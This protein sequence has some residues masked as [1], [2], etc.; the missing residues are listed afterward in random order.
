MLENITGIHV[1]LDHVVKPNSGALLDILGRRAMRNP[2][3]ARRGT[4]LKPVATVF[5]WVHR[6]SLSHDNSS[7]YCS[8]VLLYLL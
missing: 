1:T 3:A 4:A 7:Y 6:T 5:Y 2:I 8:E